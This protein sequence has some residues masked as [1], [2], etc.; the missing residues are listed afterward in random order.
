MAKVSVFGAAIRAGHWS[1]VLI[2]VLSSVA[3][4]FFYLRVIVL[5]Y[6]QE[7]ATE[8]AATGPEPAAAGP[9]WLAGAGLLA[10]AVLTLVIGVFPQLV[11]GLLEKA[12]VLTW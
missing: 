8:P 6:M 9:G 11:L 10:P 5:M 7:P 3:A 12:S 2:G 1:L 4:A